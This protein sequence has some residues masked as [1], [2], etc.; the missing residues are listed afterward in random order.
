[1]CNEIWVRFHGCDHREYYHTWLCP[2]ARGLHPRDDRPLDKTTFLPS[3]PPLALAGCKIKKATK[4]MKGI[5][6]E[7]RRNELR[8][9]KPGEGTTPP[10]RSV[11]NTSNVST[12]RRQPFPERRSDETP[13]EFLYPDLGTTAAGNTYTDG[14]TK[15]EKD[16]P[17]PGHQETLSSAGRAHGQLRLGLIGL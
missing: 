5:C 11:S 9:A 10:P 12:S 17:E 6:E 1:M 4:P 8:K 15:R 13:T 14:D 3:P 16:K 7:C 2:I